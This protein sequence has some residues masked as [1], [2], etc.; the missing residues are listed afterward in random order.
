ML[1]EVPGAAQSAIDF[2][3][4]TLAATDRTRMGVAPQMPLTDSKA[5]NAKPAAKTIRIF[6]HHGLYLEVSPCG[7]KWWRLKYRYAGKEKRVSLGIYRK[8]I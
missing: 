2:R 1:F 3:G 5:R 8:S 7:G 6:D 4:A